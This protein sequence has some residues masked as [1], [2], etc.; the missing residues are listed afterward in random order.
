MGDGCNLELAFELHVIRS[1]VSV[2]FP[3]PCALRAGID[4]PHGFLSDPITNVE[5]REGRF[6]LRTGPT[7]RGRIHGTRRTPC[8]YV[9]LDHR[10]RKSRY[11]FDAGGLDARACR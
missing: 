10:K 8:V 5:G 1:R 2:F 6:A 7:G 3:E 9:P 4:K 11:R